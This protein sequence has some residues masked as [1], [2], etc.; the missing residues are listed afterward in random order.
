MHRYKTVQIIIKKK[1]LIH[2]SRVSFTIF[3]KA[4]EIYFILNKIVTSNWRNLIGC[5]EDLEL[6]K[7]DFLW[8]IKTPDG[9]I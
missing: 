8:K 3:K 7:T 1:A 5:L 4:P 6:E 9:C 2:Q